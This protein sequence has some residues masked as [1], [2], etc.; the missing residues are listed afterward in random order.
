[1]ANAIKFSKVTA[2]PVAPCEPNTLFFLP[3]PGGEFFKLYISSSTGNSVHEHYV[4][5]GSGPITIPIDELPEDVTINYNATTGDVT[6]VTE[7]FGTGTLT[8]TP[9]YNQDQI[10]GITVTDGTN[11]K[12][13]TTDYDASGNLINISIS[14]P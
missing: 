3:L 12:V 13:Y 2:I 11:T 1:M 4:G 8:Y 9:A 7:T 6:S 14:L 5:S 10:S